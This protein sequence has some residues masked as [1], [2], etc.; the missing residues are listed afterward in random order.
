MREH[1]LGNLPR[2]HTFT[3]REFLEVAGGVTGLGLLG[4][5]INKL[6]LQG[7]L[8]PT[9]EAA[10]TVKPPA[11]IVPTN[12]PT[13]IPTEKPS[14]TATLKSTEIPTPSPDQLTQ[15][16]DP[17]TMSNINGLYLGEVEGKKFGMMKP[18]DTRII[19]LYNP[20]DEARKIT[21]PDGTVI[22]AIAPRGFGIDPDYLNTYFK[23]PNDKSGITVGSTPDGVPVKLENDIW[24]TGTGE[25]FIPFITAQPKTEAVYQ[26]ID[27]GKI[28]ELDITGKTV[29]AARSMF[30]TPSTL[31]QRLKTNDPDNL[32]FK[33]IIPAQVVAVEMNPNGSLRFIQKELKPTASNP[34]RQIAAIHE[35]DFLAPAEDLTNN[36]TAKRAIDEFA[37]ALAAAGVAIS[38]S[39]IL[40][41]GFTA[42]RV[43]GADPT[44]KAGIKKK[45]YDIA[46]VTID[47]KQAGGEYPLMIKK[48]GGEW[49]SA[50]FADMAKIAGIEVVARK[51]NADSAM[52]ETTTAIIMEI[53]DVYG[54]YNAKFDW[55]KVTS[56]W[57]SVKK[58][59]LQGKIPFESELFER[60][61]VSWVQQDI[62]FSQDNNMRF[63]GDSLFY[64]SFLQ[65]PAIKDL[66]PEK[67]KEIIFF[68]AAAKLLA[69][70]QIS[71]IDL[72]TEIA[73]F[74]MFRS[75]EFNGPFAKLGGA[76]F[77]V[78]L[79][80]FAKQIKPD[81]KL[82]MTE[83]MIIDGRTDIADFNNH[84]RLFFNLLRDL[85]TKNALVDGV[86]FEDT[87]W[88]GSPPTEQSIL[89]P[90]SEAKALGYEIEA[91]DLIVGIGAKN[92]IWTNWPARV[93]TGTQEEM[94]K[95][96]AMTYGLVLNSYLKAGI[97]SFGF[98]SV[99]YDKDWLKA[100]SNIFDQSGNPKL[101]EFELMKV[102]SD[103]L[104]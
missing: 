60:N 67:Q 76:D 56:D 54:T 70:P 17:P 66:P 5:A 4:Y 75:D 18:Y 10:P 55:T 34:S 41:R 29:G 35:I 90:I 64:P 21:K 88:V 15:F 73:A 68:T 52:L 14:P 102:V 6:R 95:Q 7:F 23:V 91:P 22:D 31:A 20:K 59:L 33:S 97:K 94:N 96:Q 77:L 40:K 93:K 43:E 38:A 8:P 69:F 100:D 98:H 104:Q 58:D 103:S 50:N 83:D 99:T 39:E 57:D 49:K 42:M 13:A 36:E 71:K 2:K 63:I 16:A 28:Q 12:V 24:K 85:K 87:L 80:A 11:A 44:D 1:H 47:D 84:Y 89:K 32:I 82:M 86:K 27:K 19:T 26:V 62:R 30:E 3:R 37:A 61:K 51:S 53:G 92:P 9:A 48:E 74:Q 25:V 81:I 45:N 79:A 65:N 101:A 72:A 78:E 46:V